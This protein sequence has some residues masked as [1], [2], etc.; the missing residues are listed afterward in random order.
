MK[1]LKTYTLEEVIKLYDK[2]QVKIA[3]KQAK[4]KAGKENCHK[5][6]FNHIKPG[7]PV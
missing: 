5:P 6:N 7:N 2:K 4:I 3:T 1:K